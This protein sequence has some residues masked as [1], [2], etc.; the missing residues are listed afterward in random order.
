MRKFVRAALVAAAL[1]APA[2]AYAQG[3][4][5]N[6]GGGDGSVSGRAIQLVLMLT[7]LSLAP[8]RN[9][10]VYSL[11]LEMDPLKHPVDLRLVYDRVGVAP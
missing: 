4:S 8:A 2:A 1:A 5:L 3:V 6:L 10:L 9:Q 11:H 7:V